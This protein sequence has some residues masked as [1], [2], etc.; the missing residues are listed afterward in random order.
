MRRRDC[1]LLPSSRCIL[2]VIIMTSHLLPHAPC[3][4]TLPQVL[5][6]AKAKEEEEK[7]HRFLYD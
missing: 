7:N 3:A 1:G 2:P 6:E 4:R 5:P